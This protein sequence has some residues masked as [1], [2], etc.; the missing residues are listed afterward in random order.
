M[1]KGCWQITENTGECAAMNDFPANIQA[2]LQEDLR[3]PGILISLIL[4]AWVIYTNDTMATDGIVYLDAAHQISL[5]N[6]NE[7]Y[8]IYKW[9][10]F[11]I[12]IALV[13]KLTFLDVTYAGLLLNTTFFAA[14]PWVFLTVLKAMG[15]NR[16]VMLS[17]LII[18]LVAPN[19]N[20]YRA[21]ILRGIGSWVF[22]LLSLL[23]MI[24][25]LQS[26]E[27]RYAYFW[28]ATIVVATLFRFELI[29]YAALMPVGFLFVR[30]LSRYSR[31][32]LIST[33]YTP[34]LIL[35]IVLAVAYS[36]NIIP[37]S[38]FADLGQ[39]YD[40]FMSSI[41]LK[42]P[43]KVRIINERVLNPMSGD[44]GIAGIAALL[45]LILVTTI[46]KKASILVSFLAAY[47]LTKPAIRSS[48]SGLPIILWIILVNL[49]YL[50]FYLTWSFFMTGRVTMPIA[51]SAAL[52]ASF[53]LPHFVSRS[54]NKQRNLVRKGGQ[55]LVYTLIVFMFLDGTVSFGHSK[56][57]FRKSGEWLRPK[58]SSSTSEYD[59]LTNHGLIS[60]YAGQR[61]DSKQRRAELEFQFMIINKDIDWSV[62]YKH[63]YLALYTKNLPEDLM[64]TMIGELSSGLVGTYG[65]GRIMI[66]SL[67]KSSKHLSGKQQ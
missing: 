23:M 21:D 17:G 29:V 6:W 12:L 40:L 8:N 61:K 28:F 31:L 18:I 42:I 30:E 10:L 43:E 2:W 35:V 63:K 26:K 7:A 50:A 13:S 56:E 37:A 62:V 19:I 20:E 3:R 48:I 67:E 27:T 60:H 46:I 49:F 15:G 16:A 58:V 5:G 66:F 45:A 65:N 64:N 41:N 54:V 55:Y 59:L 34:L 25:L 39:Y 38:R 32:R 57:Y 53:A 24:R 52:I 11:P 9:L 33:C 4:S 51:L 1:R 14:L 22:F 47:V 36:L 44:Y